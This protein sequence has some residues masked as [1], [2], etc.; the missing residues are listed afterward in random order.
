MWIGFS[1]LSLGV[2]VV[3]GEVTRSVE[4]EIGIERFGVEAI[5]G[6]GVFLGDVSVAHELADDSAVFAFGERVIV[7]VA[8]ARSG[9]FDAQ[10]LQKSGDVVIDVLGSSIR[11]EAANFEWKALEQQSDFG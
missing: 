3:D 6:G 8:R 10:L 7:G 9:E 4:V 2:Y 11:M 1:D 5:D